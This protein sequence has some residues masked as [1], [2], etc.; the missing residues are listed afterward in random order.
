M[1][2][3]KKKTVNQCEID[4]DIF[5]YMV[6]SD[7]AQLTA[8]TLCAI[9]LQT[10]DYSSLLSSS[11]GFALSSCGPLLKSISMKTESRR[12][13]RRCLIQSR[14]L[15]SSYLW[16]SDHTGVF[17][18]LGSR[19]LWYGVWWWKRVGGLILWQ[20]RWN[21]AAHTVWPSTVCPEADGVCSWAEG[22]AVSH[23]EHCR[24][25]GG[26]AAAGACR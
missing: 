17:V 15:G 25:G 8:E 13:T 12:P 18:P 4:A 24:E 26:D 23:H 6:F 7:S 9:W 19:D 14:W 10:W 16:Q 11:W 3:P 21:H 20:L 22:A 2:I 1:F 5:A